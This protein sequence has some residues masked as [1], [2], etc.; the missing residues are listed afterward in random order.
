M[1]AFKR[2]VLPMVAFAFLLR[3]ANGMVVREQTLKS[4]CD[5]C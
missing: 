4:C 3:H 1:V 5:V 2:G